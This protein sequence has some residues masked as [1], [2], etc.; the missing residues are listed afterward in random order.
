MGWDWLG[1]LEYL[2]RR[3]ILELVEDR[4]WGREIRGVGGFE[5]G[6]VGDGGGEGIEVDGISTGGGCASTIL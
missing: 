5:E 4:M 3:D 1:S 6:E 2:L